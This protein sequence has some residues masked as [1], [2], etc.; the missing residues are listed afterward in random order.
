RIAQDMTA[1]MGK[2]IRE[3][4]LETLRAAAILRFAAGEAWRAIGEQYEPSVP[5]QRLYTLR[6]PLGV[7]GLITPWNFPVAIPVWKLAPAL[8]WGNSVVLK[9]SPESTVCAMLLADAL[10]LPDDVLQVVPGAAEAGRALVECA[11]I[12]AVSFPGSAVVGR[13]VA[14]AAASR[15]ISAQ[16][17]M[18]G[19]NAV[20]VLADADLERSASAIASS[21]MGYAGQKCAAARRVIAV[22]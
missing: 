11:A 8:A 1:E 21:A 16:A 10:V 4:K 20:I 22:G 2:P 17:E 13:E 12:D 6:R 5:D 3:S 19:Q 18:G 14:V 9:P 15:G 7:V